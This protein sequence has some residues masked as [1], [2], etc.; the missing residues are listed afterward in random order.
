MK[1]WH[2]LLLVMVLLVSALLCPR[3]LLRCQQQKLYA[4]QTGTESEAVMVQREDTSLLQ[5]I[6]TIAQHNT[7]NTVEFQLGQELYYDRET[8]GNK[9]LTELRKMGR[10]FQPAA[11]LVEAL[12]REEAEGHTM[13]LAYACVVSPETGDSFF[14]AMSTYPVILVMDMTTEKIISVSNYNALEL[15]PMTEALDETAE[16][17]GKTAPQALADY[18]G[19]Q[20]VESQ[21]YHAHGAVWMLADEKGYAINYSLEISTHVLELLPCGEPLEAYTA[22][23]SDIT[24]WE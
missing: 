15:L 8:L 20:L 2:G 5:R 9:F 1:F 19:V 3:V 12:E 22:P 10:T 17:G 16:K 7:I 11:E 14:L 23:E 21:I 6:S 18:W 4:L 24:D 13:E